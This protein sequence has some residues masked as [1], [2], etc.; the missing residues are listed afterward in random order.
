MKLKLLA[1]IS[2]R[3]GYGY[4]HSDVMLRT[5][6]LYLCT[7]EPL[8]P[9]TSPGS[10]LLLASV[11]HTCAFVPETLACV[12]G[13]GSPSSGGC[14]AQAAPCCS[15]MLP[16]LINPSWLVEGLQRG[17]L[18]HPLVPIAGMRSGNAALFGGPQAA[19][20]HSCPFG[21]QPAL[22]LFLFHLRT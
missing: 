3:S 12:L 19:W 11:T 6:P 17:C 8:W 21:L 5:V 7:H 22:I 4:K 13:Q 1:G 18:L 15:F 9:R 16:I 2:G 14:P 10:Q 20:D